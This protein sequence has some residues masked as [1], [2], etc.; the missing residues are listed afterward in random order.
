MEENER[1]PSPQ[2]IRVVIDEALRC[3]ANVFFVQKEFSNRNTASVC[4]DTGARAVEI[5][6]LS[7]DWMDEMKNITDELCKP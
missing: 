1:E 5:N 2:T 6:P 4:H 3:R 7:Y